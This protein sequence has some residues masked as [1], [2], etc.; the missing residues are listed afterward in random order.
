[1][2]KSNTS[3]K[4]RT[5]DGSGTKKRGQ[6]MISSVD[7]FRG[8]GSWDA[9]SRGPQATVDGWRE[10]EQWLLNSLKANKRAATC[11]AQAKDTAL[12]EEQLKNVRNLIRSATPA[13]SRLKSLQRS[14][15]AVKKKRD[16]A[17]TQ[18][19]SRPNVNVKRC[20]RPTMRAR[21]TCKK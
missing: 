7:A 14:E 3:K 15:G 16:A 21:R 19:S 6:T 20:T 5:F 13:G 4:L 1:M 18:R 12:K 8:F 11:A 2:S 17:H 9:S 10:E